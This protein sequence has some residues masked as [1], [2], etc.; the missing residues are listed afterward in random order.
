MREQESAIDGISTQ[1]A[2][3]G[4]AIKKK[5]YVF[6]WVL[7]SLVI[8]I[9]ALGGYES[10]TQKN[11]PG[12]SFLSVLH[13]FGYL[14]PYPILYEPSKGIWHPIGWV[15]SGMMV[16]MMLYSVRK[17]FSF[18]NSFGSMR[19]W[20]HAHMFLGIVGPVLVTLHTT[21][22]FHGLIAT[23][24]YCMIVTMVFGI[25]GRYIYV[26]IPRGIS[27]AEL[28]AKE[29][30]KEV[31]ELDKEFGATLS[32]AHLTNLLD[33][34][35]VK[36][37]N[38]FLKAVEGERPEGASA[39]TGTLSSLVNEIQ[40]ANDASKY[41]STPL[42]LFSMVKADIINIFR[43]MRFKRMLRDT[44]KVE[45]RKRKEVV[46]VLKKK[47][48]L[49]RRKNFLFTSHKLLHHWHVLHVP[50]AAVMFLIMF[51]HIMIYYMFRSGI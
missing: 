48:V 45:R 33:E 8:V 14:K 31:E 15:G 39:G 3:L 9:L 20:L 4:K 26:Q 29:I 34:L 12:L 22:K 2:E 36:D 44:Y 19:N 42:A 7:I 5:P 47:A 27:G 46:A 11:Y 6:E 21:F 41:K 28:G 1:K 13:S 35:G 30:E 37:P 40:A 24:F 50:L 32:R 16:V 25:I 51:L 17:R 38:R 18:L 10:V 23:S 43:V 49:I